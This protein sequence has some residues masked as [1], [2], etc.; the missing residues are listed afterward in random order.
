MSDFVPHG[1]KPRETEMREA[2]IERLKKIKV[3]NGFWFDV[4]IYNETDKN[5]DIYPQI[6]IG[7]GVSAFEKVDAVQ[8]YMNTT[9]PI[10]VVH[11]LGEQDDSIEALE[12]LKEDF[13]KGIYY[14]ERNPNITGAYNSSS[15]SIGSIDAQQRDGGTDVAS[16]Q[17]SITFKYTIKR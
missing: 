6:V 1:N 3:S 15:A 14:G 10:W 4:E 13:Y 11:E 2:I 9:L 8:I 17:T 16:I 7:Q 12:K 5:R